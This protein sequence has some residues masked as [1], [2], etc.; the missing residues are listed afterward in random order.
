M[1]VCGFFRES[2]GPQKSLGFFNILAILGNMSQ[3]RWTLS[4]LQVPFPAKFRKGECTQGCGLC[5]LC[6]LLWGV[7]YLL[8]HLLNCQSVELSC[9][10]LFL[11]QI[12]LVELGS[13]AS[14]PTSWV[15]VTIHL[16]CGIR[17]PCV[18]WVTCQ[19]DYN[20][21]F[22]S[23]LSPYSW[24]QGC[25][26]CFCF[27]IVTLEGWTPNWMWECMNGLLLLL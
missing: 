26:L 7:I 20:H 10:S 23:C 11:E 6:I 3:R 15:P 16:P 8:F 22:S 2:F 27:Q 13:H 19:L 4:S 24:A 1:R 25:V 9:D 17:N 14:L 5:D 21:S 18:R 12:L